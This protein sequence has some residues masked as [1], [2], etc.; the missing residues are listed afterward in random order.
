MTDDETCRNVEARPA[1]QILELLQK[2]GELS[3]TELAGLIGIS[4]P[5]VRFWLVRMRGEKTIEA[6]SS[7]LRSPLTRYRMRPTRKRTR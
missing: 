1:P 2:R 4:S 5:A 3:A 7:N 6:T